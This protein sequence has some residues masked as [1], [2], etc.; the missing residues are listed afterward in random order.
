MTAPL[1]SWGSACEGLP[2]V[3]RRTHSGSGDEDPPARLLSGGE[4]DDRPAPS[5]GSFPIGLR[6]TT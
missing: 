1:S 3:E 6:K 4:R 5:A 2:G